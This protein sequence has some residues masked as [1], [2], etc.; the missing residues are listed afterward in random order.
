MTIA[1]KLLGYVT[2]VQGVEVTWGKDDCTSFAAGW[3][4]LATGVKLERT[5]FTSREEAHK[6]I[7]QRGSLL[8]IWAAALADFP[9]TWEP[10]IGDVGVIETHKYGQVGCIFSSDGIALWRTDRGVSIIR[11]RGFVKAWSIC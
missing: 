11:P 10:S 2:A 8:T 7:A 5:P 3:V 1:D 6:L 4:E 9:E